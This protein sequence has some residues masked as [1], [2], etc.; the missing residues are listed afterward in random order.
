V[1]RAVREVSGYL[2]ST[3]AVCR[4]SYIDPTIV[5]RYEEGDTIAAALERL[6]E[7]G[8]FGR[9]ATQGAVERAVLRLLR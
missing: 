1:N 5:E 3:P 4:G 9:P 7:D 8:V 2:G 6:G